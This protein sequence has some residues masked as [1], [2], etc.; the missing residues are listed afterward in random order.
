M[1]A[2]LKASAISIGFFD[3]AIA[4]FIN[5]PSQPI[6]IAIVASDAVPIPASIMTGILDCL[7]ISEIFNLL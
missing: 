3:I 4:E 7:I 6:S 1:T 2:F 5:T